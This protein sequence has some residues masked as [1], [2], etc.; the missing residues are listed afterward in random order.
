METDIV[1]RMDGARV[2]STRGA[3]AA[4]ADAPRASLSAWV[5][6]VAKAAPPGLF[7]AWNV[8]AMRDAAEP[9]PAAAVSLFGYEV[10]LDDASAGSDV[11]AAASVADGGRAVLAGTPPH[12]VLPWEE[13][14]WRSVRRFCAEWA[15]RGSPLWEG[16]DDLWL[17]WDA[18]DPSA[19]RI[20][21]VFFGPRI[22]TGHA[23]GTPA[24]RTMAVL[25]AGF[26]TLMEEGWSPAAAVRARACLDA[27]P[28]HARVFQA[29]L[30]LSR[31]GS[32]VRLCVGNLS[33]G[34]I[35][36]FLRRS[37]PAVAHDAARDALAR[38]A[39]LSVR[40]NLCID[41]DEKVGRRVGLE[42]YPDPPVGPFPPDRRPWAAFLDAL[43]R[44]G[45]AVPARAGDL[46]AL[47]ASVDPPED[48]VDDEPRGLTGMDALLAARYRR[49]LLVR[50]HHVKLSIEP[51][52]PMTAKAYVAVKPGWRAC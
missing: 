8:A 48:S 43:M 37:A 39:P 24:E 3:A 40:I 26:G 32:P 46:L 5:G 49:T 35:D 21:S 29:G 2:P 1:A 51:D 34:E 52:R 36:R 11:L 6:A 30:M 28:E 13:A 14:G 42:C 31:P 20:P 15:D 41:V 4:V 45:A 33:A 23:A 25:R 18:A 10:R 22:D 50:L 17:E 12:P 44:A 47:P 27:L 16:A 9:L 38:W 7:P 19:P